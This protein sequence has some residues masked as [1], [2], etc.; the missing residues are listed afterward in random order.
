MK[1]VTIAAVQ[2]GTRTARGRRDAHDVV[3][4]ETRAKLKKGV[5]GY[6]V[7][8]VVLSEAVQAVGQN[9]EQA[10]TTAKPGPFLSAYAEFAASEKCV[11][12]GTLKLA[13]GGKVYNTIAFVGPDGI[14]GFYRKTFL[15]DGERDEGLTPGPGAEVF[16]TPVGRLGGVICFDLNYER[17]RRQYRALK[18]DILTFSSMYHGGLMQGMW[19][20]DCRAFFASALQMQGAGILDP[21]GQPVRLTDCY[22]SV[23]RATVN[24]DR[25]MVH[26][27]FNGVKFP[28]IERKY[29][30]EVRIEQP[31]NIG[32]ALIYSLTEKRTAMDIAEEF[33]LELLD[34]YFERSV[35]ANDLARG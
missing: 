33:E 4:H 18:P 11:V 9:M 10:E 31:A 19:A 15:T 27:D 21:F 24:L 25:V 12:A 28:Q 30:G 35:T 5:S 17:L 16:D 6:G 2:F 22:C 26:I 32:S 7:D 34:D 3:L 8:L 13:E 14:I 20:Y 29:L 1:K 23:A